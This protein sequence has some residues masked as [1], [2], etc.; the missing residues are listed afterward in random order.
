MLSLNSV[1]LNDNWCSR[2]KTEYLSLIVCFFFLLIILKSAVFIPF[3]LTQVAE[4]FKRMHYAF[5]Y[6]VVSSFEN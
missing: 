6:P 5:K 4:Y 2:V 1:A 3:N